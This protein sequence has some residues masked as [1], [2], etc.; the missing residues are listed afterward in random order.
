MKK[1]ILTLVLAVFVVGTIITSCQSSATKVENAQDNLSDAKEEVVVAKEELQQALNDSIQYFKVESEK[2]INSNELEIIELKAKI[3]SGKTD[4]KA[5]YEK[6]IAELEQKNMA[7]KKRL[8]E[9]TPV[10]QSNWESFKSEFNRDM[11]VLGVAL[12]DLTVKNTK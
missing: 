6:Q 5:E 2:T 3:A 10:D 8:F 12:K 7:L 1:N 11:N 9:Y 4:N